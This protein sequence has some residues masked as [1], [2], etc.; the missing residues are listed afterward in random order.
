MIFTV[1]DRE[2]ERER[3]RW[4]G[5]GGGTMFFLSSGGHTVFAVAGSSVGAIV[6][7]VIAVVVVVAIVAGG[8]VLYKSRSRKG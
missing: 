8:I 5:G 6:G 4:G 2:R 1:M 3:E 7:A